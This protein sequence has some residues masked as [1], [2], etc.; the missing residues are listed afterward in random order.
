[1]DDT[2]II[3]ELMK[4]DV[5]KAAIMEFVALEVAYATKNIKANTVNLGKKVKKNVPEKP[6]CFGRYYQDNEKACRACRFA[7]E[8]KKKSKKT[9]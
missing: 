6:K 4:D 7:P 3:D 2:K 9:K 5:V 1:M 8:C